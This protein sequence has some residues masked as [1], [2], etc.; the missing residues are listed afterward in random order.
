MANTPE[1]EGQEEQIGEQEQEEEMEEEVETY[2]PPKHAKRVYQSKAK[3][4][5]EDGDL[6]SITLICT[7]NYTNVNKIT[8]CNHL[9]DENWH[10]WKE[11]MRQVFYNCDINEYVTGEIKCPNEAIDPI[12]TLN[13]D[14]NDS[15][16]QQIIIH[17]VTS[18]QMNHWHVGSKSSAEDMFSALSITHDNK[19]HRTVNH[20]Q[21]LLYETKL[22]DAD[23]LLKHL[24]ILK[25]YCDCI[26]R[27]PNAKFHILGNLYTP[28]PNPSGLC[29]DAWTVRGLCSDFFQLEVLPN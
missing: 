17:N 19:V 16:V 10:E 5:W 2:V 18:S 7:R 26:N 13:W 14:K 4:L 9:T 24:D 12:G 6:P 22:L 23:D 11:R 25:S 29:S 21:S 8:E 28:P 3:D 15:R 27:F 20:I 1:A